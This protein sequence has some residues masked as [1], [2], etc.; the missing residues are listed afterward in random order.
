MD[1]TCFATHKKNYPCNFVP[2]RSSLT[3]SLCDEMTAWV[4]SSVSD[5]IS[6]KLMMFRYIEVEMEKYFLY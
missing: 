3:V 1:H 4:N 5:I 6:I 2:V